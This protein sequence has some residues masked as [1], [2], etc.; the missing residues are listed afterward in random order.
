MR[1]RGTMNTI[2]PNSMRLGGYAEFDGGRI[3]ASSEKDGKNDS[4]RGLTINTT[5]LSS[6]DALDEV[7]PEVEA[8]LTRDD[9]LGRLMDHLF[10]PAKYPAP[11]MPDFA[12]IS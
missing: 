9:D 10:N 8:A 7:A 12:N 1:I 11:P 2:N 3:P 5:P 6:L 4:G